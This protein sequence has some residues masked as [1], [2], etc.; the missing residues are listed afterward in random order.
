MNSMLSKL[1]IDTIRT[2][3]MDSV[4]RAK[5]GHPGTAMALAP[6]MYAYWQFTMYYNPA[7]PFWPGRDR[8]ILS[9]GHASILLYATVF[10]AGVKDIENGQVVDRPALTLEDLKNFRRFESRTPGHPE[11][12]L[13]AG[14]EI[15][16]GPLGQGCSSAVGMAMAER[17]LSTHY[18]RPGYNL[19]GYHITSFCGDGDIMEGVASEAASLAGHLKLGNLTWVYDSNRISIEGSTDVTFTEDVAMR[20]ASYGWQVLEVEDGNDVPAICEALKQ[21]RAETTRPTLIILKTIIGYGAPG[22]AGT[23]SAH[24]EP[25][26]MKELEGAKKAYGW[27]DDAPHFTVPDGVK[28]H[29]EALAGQRGAKAQAEWEAQFA[30]YC[31]QYPQEGDELKHIFAGTLPESWE[32][33]LPVYPADEKGIASR[34]S[35]GEVLNAI[36]AQFPWL[37][38]GAA[39]LAPSTKTLIK[40]A[41]SLQAPSNMVQEG[42]HY[43]GRNVHFGVREHAMAAICN[44]LALSGLRPFCA[45]FL[46]FSDYMKPAIRLAALMHLPVIYVFTHDSI[47]VGEDGPTHQPIEQLAQ[48]RAMPGLTILRPADA[49]EVVESWRVAMQHRAGPVALALTRQ[50]L[51]TLDR[52]RYASA[53]G[54]ARGGYV[55]ADC[56]GEPEILLMASGSEVSLVVRVYER[57]KAEGVRARVV[58][59]PSFE[60]FEKQD[61]AYRDAV[62][63][64]SVR[65]RVGVEMASRFG[66]DRYVGLDGAVIAMNSFGESGAAAELMEK[67]GFTE[68][69]VYEQTRTLLRAAED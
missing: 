60:L 50:N 31:A 33:D 32:K 42:A 51:P 2:L 65:K 40:G 68:Q 21:G 62:L 52:T 39:D 56:E 63:P 8:F 10:L 57:L 28:E 41:R 43:D 29:F 66:W 37:V 35:S 7:D 5:S 34:Q 26:G 6:A 22:K 19:F 11:Y 69:A 49:N 36:A 67:F 18:G 64:P 12:G 27:P 44:G 48:F 1:G 4:E 9:G 38:G 14:V 53:A 16:T 13:T 59:M 20:F 3:V 45:G 55:L 15:T 23:A 61:R 25:L 30:D 24:G 46:I 47:G 58:S 17:W 54:V